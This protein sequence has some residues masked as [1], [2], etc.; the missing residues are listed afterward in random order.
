MS[1][2]R[3]TLER[4]FETFNNVAGALQSSYG[5]LQ[6][7]AARLRF[8]LRLK[9]DDLARSLQENETMRAY[10]GRILE[11]LP[12]GVVVADVDLGLRFANPEAKRLLGVVPAE[13]DGSAED[14]P[15]AFRR[16][17]NE[18]LATDPEAE[19]CWAVESPDGIRSI[20]VNCA[21]LPDD[22][23]PGGDL[24]FILRDITEPKRAELERDF[25]RRMRAL[26]EMT[27]ILA[28]EIRNPL[29]SLELFAELIRDATKDAGEVNQWAIHLQAGLRALSSTVNNVL[30][31]HTQAPPQNLRVDMVGLLEQTAEFL[32]PLALQ[33]GMGI[34][35]LK[36]CDKL[37]LNADPNR[38]RQVFF[39]LAINAFRAMSPGGSL[40]LRIDHDE[41]DGQRWA[42]IDFEDQGVGIAPE[43]LDRIFDTGFSTNAGSPGLGLAVSKRVVEQ[44]A[45]RLQVRSTVGKGSTFSLW[46]P[47]GGDEA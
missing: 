4:A 24:V 6:A 43:F 42:R 17:L 32:Q 19:R 11:G 20:A 12:C 22:N 46:L 8:E 18:M 1:C 2:E 40:S 45:G 37:L 14:L 25:S 34:T 7:E 13:D 16:L 27:A 33:R 9:N 3:A 15:E 29:G 41:A 35:F 47:M 44:H 10:L 31:L 38:L 21:I 28:H 26:A 36:Q 23:E 30:Q 39:N 5:N